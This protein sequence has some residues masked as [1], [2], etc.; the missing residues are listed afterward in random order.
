MTILIYVYIDLSLLFTIEWKMTQTF[1]EKLRM[2][3]KYFVCN[4]VY[5]MKQL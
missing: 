3:L 2:L 5:Y 1:Y 4:D